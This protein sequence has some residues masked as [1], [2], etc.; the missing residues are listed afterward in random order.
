M[1]CLSQ[2]SVR[3]LRESGRS[4]CLNTRCARYGQVCGT[5]LKCSCLKALT[6]DSETAVSVS[7]LGDRTVQDTEILVST[8]GAFY[9]CAD[10]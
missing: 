4:D 3:S 1:W 8:A 5:L 6:E 7:K 10:G 2:G 9:S